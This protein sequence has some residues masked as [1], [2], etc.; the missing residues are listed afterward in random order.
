MIAK[1]VIVSLREIRLVNKTATFSFTPTFSYAPST[2]MIFYYLDANGVIVSSRV[3]LK[4]D[5]D[6]PN[7]VRKIINFLIFYF[8]QAFQVELEASMKTVKPGKT[9]TLKVSSLKFST[10]SIFAQDVGEFESLRF[11]VFLLFQRTT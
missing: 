4:L 10:V 8:I 9:F 6:L 5:N 3:N 11:I 7:F 2:N 1:G